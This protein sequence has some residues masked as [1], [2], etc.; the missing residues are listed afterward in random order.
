MAKIPLACKL[1]GLE[2]YGENKGGPEEPTELYRTS[3]S[4]GQAHRSASR[5]GTSLR[6]HDLSATHHRSPADEGKTALMFTARRGKARMV[7]ALLG[8]GA[9]PSPED[10]SGT[11]VLDCARAGG[12]GTVVVE[13]L[14]ALHATRSMKP[15]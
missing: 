15:R 2:A 12:S 3:C 4:L 9:D 6:R 5:V 10:T 8:A 11:S 7:L 14:E 13:I 1:A